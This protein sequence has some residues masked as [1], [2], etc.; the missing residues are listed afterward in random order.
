MP[1]GYRLVIDGKAMHELLTG[2]MGPVVR[3]HTE[4]CT[5]IQLRAKLQV[6]AKN[7]RLGPA[8][9]SNLADTIVKRFSA[10][11]LSVLC[12][13][14]SPASYAGYVHDGTPPHI[15]RARNAKALRFFSQTAAKTGSGIVFRQMV[16]H[17]GTKPNR[18]LTDPM[19]QVLAETL[20]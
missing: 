1:E 10:S 3:W 7:P 6:R 15:I 4:V 19:R 13:I 16:N 17:P 14:G 8:N 9:R 11:G 12:E 5:Q 20:G 18:F 2:P